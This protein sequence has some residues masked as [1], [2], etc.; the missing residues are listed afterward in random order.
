[1][2]GEAGQGG[3]GTSLHEIGVHPARPVEHHNLSG[4]QCLA[5]MR[6]Y[7]VSQRVVGIELLSNDRDLGNISVGQ[8]SSAMD[9]DITVAELRATDSSH[10]A[11][12]VAKFDVRSRRYSASFSG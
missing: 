11:G 10:I 7:T 12:F 6:V 9:T 4:Y 1:M 5:G 3:H 8:C 2:A